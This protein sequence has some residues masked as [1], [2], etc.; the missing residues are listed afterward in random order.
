MA[1]ANKHDTLEHTKQ[2]RNGTLKEG[3]EEDSG[4]LKLGTFTIFGRDGFDCGC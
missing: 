3:T 2:S 1:A 4:E